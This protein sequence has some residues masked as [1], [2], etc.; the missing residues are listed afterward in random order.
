MDEAP[1]LGMPSLSGFTGRVMQVAYWSS[2]PAL[3]S[4]TVALLLLIMSVVFMYVVSLYALQQ[5]SAA[6][7]ATP[8]PNWSDLNAAPVL[9][10]PLCITKRLPPILHFVLK[11]LF[12]QWR[13]GSQWV[14]RCYGQLI[15]FSM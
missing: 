5:G 6:A 1:N 12:F 9:L 14:V 8:N 15:L 11:F 4:L 13:H 2:P 7:T 3:R 10:E